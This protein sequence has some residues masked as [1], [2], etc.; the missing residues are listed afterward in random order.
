MSD[1]DEP[2]IPVWVDGRHYLYVINVEIPP[3]GIT[4][5]ASESLARNLREAAEGQGFR[6]SQVQRLPLPE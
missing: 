1:R 6:V 4:E 3:G 2:R 5:E